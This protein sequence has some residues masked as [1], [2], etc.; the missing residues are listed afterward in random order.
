MLQCAALGKYQSP[1]HLFTLNW[2]VGSFLTLVGMDVVNGEAMSLGQIVFLGRFFDGTSAVKFDVAYTLP[3][4]Q[5]QTLCTQCG[6]IF[7]FYGAFL[8]RGLPGSMRIVLSK[9]FAKRTVCPYT[10]EEVVAVRLLRRHVRRMVCRD[11]LVPLRILTQNGFDW[12]PKAR[13]QRS[14]GRSPRVL[15]ELMCWDGVE[16]AGVG[17]WGTDCGQR[18]DV[19]QSCPSLTS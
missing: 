2:Y 12:R 7:L 5:S 4:P 17:L 13:R 9:A 15:L 16:G 11:S 14:R 3:V 8:L 10:A 1:R 18:T 6:P 19:L